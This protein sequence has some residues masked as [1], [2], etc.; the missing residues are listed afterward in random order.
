MT[1][2]DLIAIIALAVSIL[3]AWTSFAAYRHTVR[4]REAESRLALSRERSEFLVRIDKARGTFDRLQTQLEAALSRIEAA[5]VVLRDSL[6]EPAARLVADLR[7]LAGCQRQAWSLWE[8]TYEM[9]VDGL[10]H[11]KPRFLKLIEDDEQFAQE[12]MARC[13]H[14]TARLA[15]KV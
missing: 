7:Y 3:S 6:A 1:A 9:G 14:V 4:V 2:S 13:E 10:A 12:S 15:G 8:E 11:H 5:D